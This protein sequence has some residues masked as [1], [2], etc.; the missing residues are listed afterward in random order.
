MA[1]ESAMGQRWLAWATPA[2]VDWDGVYAEHLPRVHSFFRYRVGPG[3][4]AEDLTAR[5]FEKAWVARDRYRRD[6][7]AF[8]PWLMTIARRVAIDHLR[9]RKVHLPL[10]EAM[11]VEAGPTPESLAERGSDA[12]RLAARL[13]ELP[14]RE[15]ELV[16]LKYG[17]EMT[18]R[19]IARLMGLTESNVG[20]I[21]HRTVEKLREGWDDSGGR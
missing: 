7:G 15:R 8:G 1:S 9:A 6:L 16:S 10:E 17:A 12:A 11:A 18:N 2:E 19:A 5:T 4:E 21:L 13:A 3:P 20:T 14:E